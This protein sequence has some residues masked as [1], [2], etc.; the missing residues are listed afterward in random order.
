M[1]TPHTPLEILAG[2]R[3]LTALLI[4][5]FGGAAPNGEERKTAP[6]TGDAT[7]GLQFQRRPGEQAGGAV[8]GLGA[9]GR[10]DDEWVSCPTVTFDGQTYR[11]WYSSYYDYKESLGA[12]GIGLATSQDGLHWTRANAGKPVLEPGPD[13]ALDDGQ[14]MG[15]EVLYDGETYRMWY[16][17]QPRQRH[18]SGIGYY[19]IFL[20]TSR[21]GVQWTR[22]NAGRPVLDIGSEGAFDS[23]QAATPSILRD[24]SGYQMWY[25][26]WAPETGHV[27]CAAHSRDGSAW[28]RNNA[29]RPVEGLTP[30]SAY[31][32]AVTRIGKRY[33][34][35]YMATGAQP[36]L[37]GAISSDGG[38]WKM[39]NDGRPVLT[40]GQK[41]KDF[42]NAIAGHPFLMMQGNLL[43]VWYTGYRREPNGK[44]PWR[45]RIGLAEALERGE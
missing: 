1:K 13:G 10:F 21:D 5:M 27:I 45:L 43:R 6:S 11:M 20:A 34:M 30:A 39:L 31:G 29:G 40:R 17:G 35:L 15:P 32:P 12:R 14:V 41:A 28:Q 44:F 38:H 22:A 3:L 9:T 42:D 33:L 23:V 18:S 36:E 37:Y 4:L 25:A 2:Q 26:A 19:R 24:A 7:I 16:T 8:F